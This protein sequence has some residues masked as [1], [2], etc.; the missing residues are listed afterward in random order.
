MG[1]VFTATEGI[2]GKAVISCFGNHYRACGGTGTPEIGVG[3]I[4][5]EGNRIVATKRLEAIDN[6]LET[7]CVDIDRVFTVE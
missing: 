1:A 5:S 2:D 7:R 4:G 6:S 3:R